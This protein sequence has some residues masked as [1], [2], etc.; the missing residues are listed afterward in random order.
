[1][2]HPEEGTIHAWIDGEL[3]SEEASALEAHVAECRECAERVAEARGLVAA[4]SRIVTALDIVP[5]DV[6]PVQQKKRRAWYSTTQFRAA[7]A[8]AFVAGASML[9]TRD[10][11]NAT[12]DS[13]MTA[14]APADA[15]TPVPETSKAAA[16]VSPAPVSPPVAADVSTRQREVASSAPKAKT[17]TVLRSSQAN[18]APAAIGAVAAP[19]PPAPATRA[20][21]ADETS[22]AKISRAEGDLAKKSLPPSSLMLSDV[23]VT[24]VAEARP[25]LKRIRADST[26]TSIVTL[27][28]V[29]STLQVTLTDLPPKAF[30]ADARKAERRD[31]AP[32]AQRSALQG[33]AAAATPLRINT[34]QWI[35]KRG[36]TMVLSGP[37]PR[38]KLEELRL[39]LPEDQR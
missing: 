25:E 6:I 17:G 33:N 24:G 11:K 3:S 35:D 18:G 30:T 23:V 4:S 26:S 13:V 8:I 14:A 7:A 15:P 10:N 22:A 28:Q 36:H 37:V 32:Q 12:L 16:E 2:Q 29:D 39:R 5:G 21:V 19:P 1:M 27:L 31:I 20:A 38:E 34:I 9:V